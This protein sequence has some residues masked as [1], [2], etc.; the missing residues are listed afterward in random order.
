LVK[1][2]NN[3]PEKFP[4]IPF[5]LELPLPVTLPLDQ[6]PIM[7]LPLE[8][9]LPNHMLKELPLLE[10]CPTILLLRQE[11]FIMHHNIIIMMAL[12]DLEGNWSDGFWNMCGM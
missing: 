11:I 10:T 6:L 3:F 12:L 8:F 7:I 2:I 4:T 1:T 9:L 5:L